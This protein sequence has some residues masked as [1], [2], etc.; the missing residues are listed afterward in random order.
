MDSSVQFLT[1]F[2]STQNS[3]NLSLKISFM[4]S[5]ATFDRKIAQNATA[6]TT[7]VKYEWW[8][9]LQIFVF[10]CSPLEWKAKAKL[11]IIKWMPSVVEAFIDH[12]S[13]CLSWVSSIWGNYMFNIMLRLNA[14]IRFWLVDW[15]GTFECLIIWRNRWMHFGHTLIASSDRYTSMHINNNYERHLHITLMHSIHELRLQS[16]CFYCWWILG[17]H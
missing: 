15:C 17:Q 9:K 16:K 10:F 2:L 6:T 12:I 11:G 13:K 8:E 3:S 4:E 5:V 14:W 7:N 1:L